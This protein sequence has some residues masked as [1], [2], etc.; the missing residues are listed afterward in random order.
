M[1]MLAL[2]PSQTLSQGSRESSAA[3]SGGAASA[4]PTH[5]FSEKPISRNTTCSREANELNRP[6]EGA[7]VLLGRER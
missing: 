6:G 4:G 1:Q 3:A 7:D 5:V 2:A